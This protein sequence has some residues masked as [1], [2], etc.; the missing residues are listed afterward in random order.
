[1]TNW[2]LI[3]CA[4]LAIALPSIGQ[5]RAGKEAPLRLL[6]SEVQPG[7]LSSEHHCMLILADHR[8]HDERAILKNGKDRERTIYEGDL[9]ETEWNA[10]NGILD[11][12]DFRKLNVAH[13]YVP[14]VMQS[15]HV[16]EISVM[17]EKEFQNM[18]FMD[19][20]S[21]KAYDAQLKPL[22]QWQKS[23]RSK[24]VSPSEAPPDSRCQ[25][26]NVS[27]VFSY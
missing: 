22:F 17:R 8:F 25:L 16:Y 19:D 15:A 26:D 2:K 6:I 7:A 27:G 14:L 23:F 24:R 10:L 20:K 13:G 21:R 1:M 5:E 9:S 3:V 18:E 12:D 11:S 4:L